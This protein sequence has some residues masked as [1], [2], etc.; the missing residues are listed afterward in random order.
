MW[1]KMER[2]YDV[3]PSQIADSNAP[4]QSD[5]EDAIDRDCFLCDALQHEMKDLL[6]PEEREALNLHFLG[7]MST[8][9]TAMLLTLLTGSDEDIDENQVDQMVKSAINKLRGSEVLRSFYEE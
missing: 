2:A 1:G 6:T 5:I 8:G 3:D 4:T 7:E 9:D